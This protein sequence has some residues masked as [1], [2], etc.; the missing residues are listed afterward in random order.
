MPVSTIFQFYLS[1]SYLPAKSS[2]PPLL[3]FALDR[4]SVIFMV[5][6]GELQLYS[7]YKKIFLFENVNIKWTHLVFALKDWI[8]FGDAFTIVFSVNCVHILTWCEMNALYRWAIS[9]RGVT[10]KIEQTAV[11]GNYKMTANKTKG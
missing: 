7:C 2:D 5:T 3:L 8:I 1:I 11:L 6:W 4:I 9:I 10:D